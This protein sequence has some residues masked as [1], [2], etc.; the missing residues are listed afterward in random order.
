[1]VPFERDLLFVKR[2]GSFDKIK[3][4]LKTSSK[5]SLSGIGGVGSARAP[6]VA[7]CRSMLSLEQKVTN[8]D[9]L[10]LPISRTSPFSSRPVGP[11]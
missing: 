3:E 5:V 4:I 9:R 7:V 2:N 10:L 1:M 8:S 6:I 11:L